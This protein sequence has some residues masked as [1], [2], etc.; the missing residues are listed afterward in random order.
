MDDDKLKWFQWVSINLGVAGVLFFLLFVGY[1]PSPIVGKLDAHA[2]STEELIH[3]VRELNRT[4]KVL[5]ALTANAQHVDATVCY[6]P[7][8]SLVPVP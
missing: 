4:I 7:P 8:R 3:T 6:A 2:A 5:C 1:I